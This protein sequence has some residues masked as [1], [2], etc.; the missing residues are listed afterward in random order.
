M[1]NATDEYF[2]NPDQQ[3][4]LRRGQALAVLTRDDPRYSYYG[5]TVGLVEPADGDID[6][7]AALA[8]AQGNSSTIEVDDSKTR[9][10]SPVETNYQVSEKNGS[11]EPL[12]NTPS[13][14]GGCCTPSL[15]SQ[16]NADTTSMMGKWRGPE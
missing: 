3:A 9:P 7:L 2:G 5:R 10:L 11:L 12:R 16:T 13:S 8:V 1:D 4:L 6:Q 15:S 14:S